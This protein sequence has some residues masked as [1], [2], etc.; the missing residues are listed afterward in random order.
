MLMFEKKENA[1]VNRRLISLI[2]VIRRALKEVFKMSI[3]I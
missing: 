3:Q 2:T 1:Q